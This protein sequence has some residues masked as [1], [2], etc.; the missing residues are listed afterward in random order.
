[1]RAE[2]FA[3][4]LHEDAMPALSPRIRSMLEDAPAG[5]PPLTPAQREWLLRVLTEAT[6]DGATE[7]ITRTLGILDGSRMSAVYFG[8]F[9]LTYNAEPMRMGSGELVLAFRTCTDHAPRPR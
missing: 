7:A 6:I 4:A 2:D 9:E 3:N 5:V 8:S 1:M